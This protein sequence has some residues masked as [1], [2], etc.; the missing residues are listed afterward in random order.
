MIIFLIIFMRIL[1]RFD[2][3]NS[4]YFCIL[5]VLVNLLVLFLNKNVSILEVKSAWPIFTSGR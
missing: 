1:I 5:K 4:D 2:D 3:N